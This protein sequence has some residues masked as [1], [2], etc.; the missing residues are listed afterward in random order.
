MDGV[1]CKAVIQNRSFKICT[2]AIIICRISPTEESA[3]VQALFWNRF[4]K[5]ICR[6]LLAQSPRCEQPRTGCLW[7][8]L[9][10]VLTFLPIKFGGMYRVGHIASEM[11]M[12]MWQLG[13]TNSSGCWVPSIRLGRACPLRSSL[14]LDT[15]MILLQ[16]G[17]RSNLLTY[18]IHYLSIVS[19]IQNRE[20]HHSISIKNY[21]FTGATTST[22]VQ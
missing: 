1:R 8:L 21:A 10:V 15:N 13:K 12:S 11:R 3:S 20:G 22:G 14:V 17:T 4:D 9:R 18:S 6:F 2:T 16:V 19:R 5:P 7:I